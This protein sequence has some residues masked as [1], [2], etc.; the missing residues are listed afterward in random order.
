MA[1]PPD[2]SQIGAFND[3]MSGPF[4]IVVTSA[5]KELAANLGPKHPKLVA[6]GKRVILPALPVAA[7]AVY[8]LVTNA[9]P[10]QGMERITQGI[11]WGF[12]ASGAYRTYQVTLKGK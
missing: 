2:A 9:V 4:M 8:A 10:G 12:A 5:L 7:G 3:L 1:T 11:M 6:F